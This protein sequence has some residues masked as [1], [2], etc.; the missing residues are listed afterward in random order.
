MHKFWGLELEVAGYVTT[1]SI[2]CRLVHLKRQN[3]LKA[4]ADK[5]KKIQDAVLSQGVPRDA[6]VNLGTFQSFQRHWAV[7][8]AITTL[9]N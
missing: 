6:A 3:R 1:H 2:S 7:F 5:P 8:A 4:G 9:S